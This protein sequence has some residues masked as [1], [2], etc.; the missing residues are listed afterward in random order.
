MDTLCIFIFDV[1]SS[2]CDQLLFFVMYDQLAILC[3]LT[4]L[5]VGDVEAINAGDLLSLLQ[6]CAAI[7]CLFIYRYY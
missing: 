3:S 2:F 7:C 5:W 4:A 6:Y 1:N